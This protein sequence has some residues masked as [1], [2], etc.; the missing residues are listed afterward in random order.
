MEVTLV[1]S[2]VGV[3]R[4]RQQFLTSYL[5]GDAVAVNAGCIGFYRTPREQRRIKHLFLSH[6]HMDHLASLPT[7]LVNTYTGDGDCVTVY[8]SEFVLD[9]LRRDVF[10]DRLWPDFLRLSVEGPPFLKLQLLR[11]GQTVE[12]GGLRVTP[13]AVDHLVPTMGFLIEDEAVAVVISSDTGPTG[14]LW[15]RANR[16]ANLKAVF[17][18]TAFPDALDG[19]AEASK[20][21]TPALLGREMRKVT[22]PVRFIVVHLSSRGRRQ[23]VDELNALDGAA[24]EIGRFGEPYIF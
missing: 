23:I 7:F 11:P 24:L 9:C 5:I 20:H 10:N 12:C 21:L 16:A 13:E 18:E 14:A 17:V 2:A 19:L 3:R 15:E 22:R 8:G 4:S 1:P 6:T